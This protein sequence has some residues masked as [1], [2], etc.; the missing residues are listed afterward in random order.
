[1]TRKT[2]RLLDRLIVAASVGWMIGTCCNTSHATLL[3][4]D[5]FDTTS[6]YTAGSAL[7]G[8]TGG[9]GSFLTGPWVQGGGDDHLVLATSLTRPGQPIPSIGGSAGDNNTDTCCITAR[10]GRLMSTPWGGF[11]DPDGTFYMGFLVNFGTGTKHHRVMEMWSGNCSDGNRNLQFGYSE[12]TGVGPNI[13]GMS[14]HDSSNNTNAQQ[15]LSENVDFAADQ[16]Q[17]H[18]VV[19]KF[20]MSTSVNDVISAYLDPVGIAEPGTPSQVFRGAVA[21][22]SDRSRDELR[23]RFDRHGCCDGRT[24]NFG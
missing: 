24:A 8:Q 14:V 11:A 10:D 4:Y 19:L 20:Q 17:T 1:M 3:E 6:Q 9:T 7:G 2:S 16:G 5:G 15:Q 13:A 18:F 22:R 12:F 21:D 23:L